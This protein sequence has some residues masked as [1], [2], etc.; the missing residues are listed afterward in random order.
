VQADAEQLVRGTMSVGLEQLPADR[1]GQLRDG[2]VQVEPHIRIRRGVQQVQG[3][4]HLRTHDLPPEWV[5]E[6]AGVVDRLSHPPDL[7]YVLCADQ[8]RSRHRL[9]RGVEGGPQVTT[10]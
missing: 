6:I 7:F 2:G 4:A 1:I 3:A 8:P 10:Q 5:P 9:E